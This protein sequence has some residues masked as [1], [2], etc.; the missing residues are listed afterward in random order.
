MKKRLPATRRSV[1]HRGIIHAKEGRTKFFIT[2]GLYDDGQPGEVF[3]TCDQSGSTLDG[4]CDCWAIAVSMLLQNGTTVEQLAAKFAHQGFE[5]SGRTDC[6]AVGFAQSIPDYC[7][8]WM[9][10]EFPPKT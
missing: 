7:V 4:F 9:Q 6:P 10:A 3:I 1:T 5:P 2:V 8:R